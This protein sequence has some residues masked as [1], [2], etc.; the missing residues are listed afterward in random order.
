[1]RPLLR[2]VLLITVAAVLAVAVTLG[3]TGLLGGT[4]AAPDTAAGTSAARDTA[5]GTP[6]DRDTAAP[7]RV[8]GRAAPA[9]PALDPA[10]VAGVDPSDLV[11]TLQAR[12]RHVPGDH[13]AWSTLA[14][15]YVEQARITA[16]PTFYAKADRALARAAAL[17]P[18]D[19]VLLTARATLAA[20][21]HEFTTALRSSTAAL[22]VNPYSGP[23]EAIR[24]DA[25]TEL[26]RY[27]AA[28]RA[29]HRADD[30][31]PGPSTFARLS[32]QAE[33]R[34][35]LTAATRLMRLSQQAAG[36]SASSYAFATFHLGELA[37]AAG[38][39]GP[40]AHH[41]RNALHADPAYLPALAGQARLAVARGD[42]ATAE[43]AYLRVVR[44]LPLI[45]YVVELGELYDATGRPGQA[46]QQY[47][48]ATASAR[49]AAA[50]G[51]AGDLETALFQADHGRPAVALSAA[52][53][54]WQGRQSIHTADAL[55]WALHAAG[56]DR[57]ALRFARLATR[58]GTRDARLVFHLGA[59]EAALGVPSAGAHL[60]DARALDAGVSPW[61][62]AAI[63][64]LLGGAR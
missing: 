8:A 49:L 44:G 34:G 4:S 14:L 36:T 61:R 30:L 56:R 45:E 47:A 11:G 23:A 54:E 48:V 51:V 64:A 35:D 1:M 63:A 7:A 24:S 15:A 43:R 39:P 62:E 41:Y 32:Y 40:A 38:R 58:L 60:R 20:A 33:L 52:R 25:L 31:D 59:I 13:R 21:R 22:R 57:A 10:A 55:G 37:R 9:A 3:A 19:S 50:N 18:T 46:R 5:G 28:R 17:A 6:A 12:L 2:P 53:S 29:A 27:P 42:L 16:D 26:G